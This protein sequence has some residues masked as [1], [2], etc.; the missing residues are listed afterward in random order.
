MERKRK[1]MTEG[2]LYFY[3][4]PRGQDKAKISEA[5]DNALAVSRCG[6]ILGSGTS[7]FNDGTITIEIGAYD[8]EATDFAISRT[9]KR[10]KCT[11]FEVV[12]D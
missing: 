12:W 10:L 2:S 8:C 4:L 1:R 7:L 5:I 9:C 11:D 6:R 3:S